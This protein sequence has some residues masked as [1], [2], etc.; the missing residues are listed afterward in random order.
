[1]EVF[2]PSAVCD[3]QRTC[4]SL[5]DAIVTL[6]ERN[7]NARPTSMTIFASLIRRP[8]GV[9]AGII[10]LEAKFDGRSEFLRLPNCT[11]FQART[12]DGTTLSFEISVLHLG[13]LD[14]KGVVT[15]SDGRMIH[16]V[17][18]KPG[19]P[20]MY[21]F[22][23]LDDG[24]TRQAVLLLGAERDCYRELSPELSGMKVL[25]YARVRNIPV[26]NLKVLRAQIQASGFG[27]LKDARIDRALRRAGFQF[28][29]SA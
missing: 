1:M 8:D 5:L 29:R 14:S 16:N 6:S 17:T 23:D 4:R 10:L 28:P 21:D 3:G 2:D 11:R 7:S 12:A 22:T 18:M 19:T 9:E 25:D 20:V 26:S 13:Q 24:I 15:L 27:N